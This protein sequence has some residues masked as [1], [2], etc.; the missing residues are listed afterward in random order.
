MG[1][2]MMVG[3]GGSRA[4]SRT[5]GC[6]TCD[7]SGSRR[8]RGLVYMQPCTGQLMGWLCKLQRQRLCVVVAVVVRGEQV[9][10]NTPPEPSGLPAG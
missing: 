8:L 7:T 5:V 3:A 10:V 2:C 9:A 4:A 1:A 6:N